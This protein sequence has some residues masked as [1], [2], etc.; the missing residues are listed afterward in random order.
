MKELAGKGIALEI[1]TSGLRKGLGRT[2]PGTDTIGKYADYGGTRITFGSDAHSE[3][4]IGAGFRDAGEMP[5]DD[6]L[7]PGVYIRRRFQPIES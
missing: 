3:A 4:E 6:R 1:N 7:I 5:T 2:L